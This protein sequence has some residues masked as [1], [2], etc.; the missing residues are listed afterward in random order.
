MNMTSRIALRSVLILFTVWFVINMY[1]LGTTLAVIRSVSSNGIGTAELVRKTWNVKFVVAQPHQSLFRSAASMLFRLPTVAA[2]GTDDCDGTENKAIPDSCGDDPP[3]NPCV[4]WECADT[5]ANSKKCNGPYFNSPA[6][7][8]C[9]F[10]HNV[11]CKPP[12]P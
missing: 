2:C 9:R 11:G 8:S 3:G 6:C 7:T 5:G 1:E 10:D 12:P 4:A